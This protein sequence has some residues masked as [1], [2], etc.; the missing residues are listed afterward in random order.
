MGEE[1]N[2]SAEHAGRAAAAANMVFPESA[3]SQLRAMLDQYA[4]SDANLFKILGGDQSPAIKGGSVAEELHAETFN[5]DAITK[6]KTIRA[7]TDK[8][9]EW[10]DL[11]LRPREQQADIVI[12]DGQDITHQAQA[13]YY[14]TAE[15][16]AN[17]FREMRDGVHH[18]DKVDS[19]IGPADQVNPSDGS[20][21]IQDHARRAS[22]KNA[23][24]RP[25]VSEAADRVQNRTSDQLKSDGVESRP[26][27]RKEAV[28]TAKGDEPHPDF[29][30]KYQ[31]TYS[32]RVILKNMGQAALCAGAVG[33]VVG[34]VT[35][36]HRCLQLV[37]EGKLSEDEAAVEITKSIGISAADS[38]FK[39]AAGTGAVGVAARQGVQII[40]RQTVTGLLT[41]NAIVGGGICAADAVVCMVKVA[42]GKMTVQEFEERTGKNMFSTTA[43]VSGSA[44]G[45]KLGLATHLVG[46]SLIGSM[47]GGLIAGLAMHIAVQNHIEKAYHQVISNTELL[48]AAQD[49]MT[50]VAEQ[51]AL[52]Q[53][54]FEAYIRE[55][56][57]LDAEQAEAMRQ[58]EDAGEKMRDSIDRI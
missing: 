7:F 45:M 44:I 13:K 18:Y 29:R 23:E 4:R 51:L 47:A 6:K 34:G 12:G 27:T 38:A 30:T 1:K 10:T 37:R 15:K 2:Y 9:S 39:A 28:D 35:S 55:E 57:R 21:G 22:L 19:Y 32:N 53:Q 25:N 49:T 36:T 40:G 46:A 56:Q 52:G 20:P 5:L 50:E 42:A 31:N 3:R 8:Y 26:L 14:G 54:A 41:R 48:A 17:A 16:S 24:T 58:C 33:A 11:G 43:A